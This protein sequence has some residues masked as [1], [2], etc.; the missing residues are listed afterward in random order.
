MRSWM[1]IGGPGE[2]IFIRMMVTRKR[3]EEKKCGRGEGEIKETLDG[4]IVS[5]DFTDFHRL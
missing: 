2:L 5:A 4:R 1:K 3:G